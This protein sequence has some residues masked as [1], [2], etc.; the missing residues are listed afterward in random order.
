MNDVDFQNGISPPA[1]KPQRMESS[2]MNDVDFQN[3]ISPP[4]A[5][6]QTRRGKNVILHSA[7]RHATESIGGGGQIE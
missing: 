5:K 6:P 1:A 2:F 3:G 4:A 7:P